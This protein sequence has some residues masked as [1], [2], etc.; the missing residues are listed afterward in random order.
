MLIEEDRKEAIH[1]TLDPSGR[2]DLLQ[3]IHEETDRL[4]TFVESMVEL[5]RVEAGSDPQKRG[6]V[7]V[8]GIISAA[9]ERSEHLIDG[10]HFNVRID[11]RMPPVNADTKAIAEALYNI[12]DNAVKYSPKGT[13]ITV[14]VTQQNEMARFAIEDEGK[15]IPIREREKIFE[16]FHRINPSSKGFGLGLAIVRAIIEAHSG[17]IWVESGTI[18]SNFIFEL[19]VSVH[20]GQS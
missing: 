10:H 1:R 15:G 3:V 11:D 6:P 18:G 12:F 17:K 2:G 5:A 14:R 13:T 7:S 16:K 4:N 9:M 8:E 19:P 20:E